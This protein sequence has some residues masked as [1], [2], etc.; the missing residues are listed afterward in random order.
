MGWCIGWLVALKR[1]LRLL[2][3]NYSFL[4]CNIINV[5]ALIIIALPPTKLEVFN[6]SKSDI[7]PPWEDV[8]S[9]Q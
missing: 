6:V 7:L 2:H 5:I 9:N 8:L 1:H 4:F 3:F